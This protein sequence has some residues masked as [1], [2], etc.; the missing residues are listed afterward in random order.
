MYRVKSISAIVL[1]SMNS[2]AGAIGGF[3]APSVGSNVRETIRMKQAVEGRVQS[4]IKE[5]PL[6]VP[7]TSQHITLSVKSDD[8]GGGHL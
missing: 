3:F 7:K 4:E 2:T 6:F 5:L 1:S 8:G